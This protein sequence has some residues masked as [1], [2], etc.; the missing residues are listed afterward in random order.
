MILVLNWEILWLQKLT[1]G[2]KL[3]LSQ[4]VIKTDKIHFLEG[5]MLL[6]GVFEKNI[7]LKIFVIKGL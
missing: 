3:F 2:Q 1:F 5:F 7:F 4:K 6:L